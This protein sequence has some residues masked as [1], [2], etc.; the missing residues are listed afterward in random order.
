MKTKETLCSNCD[1][2][3]ICRFVTDFITLM[4]KIDEM[5]VGCEYFNINVNCSEFRPAIHI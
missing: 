5:D 2:R 4:E 3:K 1:H